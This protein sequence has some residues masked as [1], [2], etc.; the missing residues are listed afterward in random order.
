MP[1]ATVA[2][3][4]AFLPL[5][6]AVTPESTAVVSPLTR[7]VAVKPLTLWLRPL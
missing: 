5:P 7:P 1:V 6:P 4:P 3:V 2:Y